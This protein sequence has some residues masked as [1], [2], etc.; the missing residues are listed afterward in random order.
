MGR[1]TQY[2]ATRCIPKRLYLRL[3]HLWKFKKPPHIRR[4]VTLNEKLLWKKLYGYQPVHTTITDK[5]AVREWVAGKIGPDYL[6]P[7]LGVFDSVN[8]LSLEH[9]PDAFIIKV[10]RGSGQNLIVR[11]KDM[12]DERQVRRLLRG[13]MKKNHYH[14]SK[15]RQYKDIKPRLIVEKLLTDPEGLVPMD[16]KFHCFHGQVEMIQVDIDRFGD[17]RRNFYDTDWNLLAFT[18]SAWGHPSGEPAGRVVNLESGLAG[19]LKRGPLWPNGQPV[20]RPDKLPEMIHIARTLSAEFDY[21]RVDLFHFDGKVYFGELTLHPGGGW[22][23]FYP[24]EYD[25]FFGDKLHLKKDA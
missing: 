16:F 8:D 12:V 14:L 23:R 5:Y 2:I 22:E 24:P 3:V 10:S 11:D 6:I 13:W 25:R 18:W 4:P 19:L 20:E 9:L 17:H 1:L 7:L 15:E 21:I